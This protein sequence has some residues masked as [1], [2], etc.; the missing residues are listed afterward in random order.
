MRIRVALGCLLAVLMIIGS[1]AAMPQNN[2]PRAL[3]EVTVRQKEDGKIN[4]G[5]HLMQ[6]WCSLGDCT[7]TSLTLNQ[8]HTA[9]S[10][11]PA[12]YP[13]IE[14]ASTRE[15]DLK[16][17]RD[18]DVLIVQKAG[19]D[20]GGDYVTTMRIGFE[21]PAP[22]RIASRVTSFTGG[23]VKNSDILRRVVTTD[24]VPQIGSFHEVPLDCA[25]LLPGVDAPAG[26]AIK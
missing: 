2:I 17:V 12:F 3:L 6:L 15:G 11:K 21:P 20:I 22:G 23:Y 8:C 5:L 7:L 19:S 13:K 16:V 26:V 25:V 24:Y 14:R 1:L 9:G 18:G 10:G 4:R